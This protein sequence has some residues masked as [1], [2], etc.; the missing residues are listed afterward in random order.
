[1]ARRATET[2]PTLDF[3]KFATE[4]S[5]TAELE[6]RVQRLERLVVALQAQFDHLS[7]L[8]RGQ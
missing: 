6:K 3:A 5:K 4:S 2:L 7:A 8:K 1:V